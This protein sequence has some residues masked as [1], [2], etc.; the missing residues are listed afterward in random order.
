MSDRRGRLLSSSLSPVRK[1][2]L[3]SNST[4]SDLLPGLE[5]ISR[6]RKK[7]LLSSL[8]DNINDGSSLPGTFSANDLGSSSSTSSSS[9]VYDDIEDESMDIED[10]D[11]LDALYLD[12]Y[13]EYRSYESIYPTQL[14]GE[15]DFNAQN[16]RPNQYGVT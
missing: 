11:G 15:Y 7:K 9:D 3:R 5:S 16:V 10:F 14:D 2:T 12:N 13:V 8:S 1:R 6:K 4:N